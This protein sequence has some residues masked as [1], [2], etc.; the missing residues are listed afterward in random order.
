VDC[1]NTVDL[2][3]RTRVF[4]IGAATVAASLSKTALRKEL[5]PE[6]LH[7]L[8]DAGVLVALAALIVVMFTKIETTRKF[9]IGLLI[10]LLATLAG[11]IALRTTLVEPLN[12]DGKD[13]LYL[14]GWDLSAQAAKP[15]IEKFS[16]TTAQSISRH[17]LIRCAGVSNIPALYDSSFHSASI[18]Y[19]FCYLGFLGMFAVFIGKKALS[20]PPISPRIKIKCPRETMS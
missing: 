5:V 12:Y 17:D 18:L 20:E 3:K 9:V 1:E 11:V 7:W 4:A 6:Q 10:I 8:G 2:I 13:Y 15:C 14:V 16:Q 19:V